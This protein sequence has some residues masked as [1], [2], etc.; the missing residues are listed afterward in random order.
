[1]ESMNRS[2]YGVESALSWRYGVVFVLI[3]AMTPVMAVAQLPTATILGVV[4]DSSGAIV[5]GV[6]LTARNVE[7]G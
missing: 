4:K 7:T 3:V 2:R 5:P 1:M 6:S